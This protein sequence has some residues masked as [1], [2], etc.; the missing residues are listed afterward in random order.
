MSFV[1]IIY[2]HI[3]E[4]Y[5]KIVLTLY[6]DKGNTKVEDFTSLTKPKKTQ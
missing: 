1:R 2:Q 4:Q 3:L 5:R 6:S